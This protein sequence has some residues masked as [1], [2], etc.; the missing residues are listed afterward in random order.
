MSSPV[1]RLVDFFTPD[2]SGFL[3][4]DQD[5]AARILL[6]QCVVD[7]FSRRLPDWCPR[8]WQLRKKCGLFPLPREEPTNL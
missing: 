2:N 8:D 3:V 5:E 6:K 7:R 1:Y 4:G